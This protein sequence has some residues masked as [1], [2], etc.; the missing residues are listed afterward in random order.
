M[1]LYDIADGTGSP[2]ITVDIDGLETDLA[3]EMYV[4]ENDHHTVY[5]FDP[6]V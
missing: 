4:V 5:V 3:I 2:Y 6:T 1:G